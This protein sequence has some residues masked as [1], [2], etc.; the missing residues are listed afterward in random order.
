MSE[1]IIRPLLIE[2][3]AWIES[4]ITRHWGSVNL[5]SRGSLYQADE[6]PGFIAILENEP[7]GLITYHIA[8]HDCEIISINSLVENIGI[9]TSLI[10]LVKQIAKS[11]N[12]RR[13]W[14]IT[15]NDNLPALRYYQKRGFRLVAI[16]KNAIDF[17]RKLKPEIPKLGLEGIPIMDEI[18]LEMLLD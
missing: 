17:S 3:R 13:L 9:G 2:D 11:A 12:C 6:L 14:L 18:E 15:T 1:L 16:H 7:V 5:V 10:N 4:F 8:G